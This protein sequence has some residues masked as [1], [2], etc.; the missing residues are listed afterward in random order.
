M[1]RILWIALPI[2][3]TAAS[4]ACN[5]GQTTATPTPSDDEIATAVSETLT[6]EAVTPLSSDTAPPASATPEPTAEMTSTSTATEEPALTPTHTAPPQGVSLNC[7]GTYQRFR[8]TDN[9]ADGKILSVDDWSGAAWV[10]VWNYG[11]PDNPFLELFTG[12]EDL[13]TFGGCQ[14]LVIAPIRTGSPHVPVD[15]RIFAWNGATMTQVYS[16][17]K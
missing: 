3:L 4:L 1:R 10:N 6:A 15:V 7:D 13:Y 14:Q 11:P 8:I 2:T 5:I 12:E 16:R 9:G 17:N